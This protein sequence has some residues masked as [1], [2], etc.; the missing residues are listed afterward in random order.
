MQLQGTAV[1]W[2]RIGT[3]V[4]QTLTVALV[5]AVSWLVGGPVMAISIGSGVAVAVF[6]SDLARRT[7]GHKPQPAFV[8]MLRRAPRSTP[9][10]G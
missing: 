2:G 6:A 4:M 5:F 3:T 7:C 8:L 9:E 1:R 10:S